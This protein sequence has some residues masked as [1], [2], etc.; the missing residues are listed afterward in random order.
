M[1]A[2]CLLLADDLE[3]SLKKHEDH[4][5]I[6]VELHQMLQLYVIADDWLVDI[7]CHLEKKGYSYVT[8][9]S[10][11]LADLITSKSDY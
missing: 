6:C 4:Q 7:F 11:Q 8:C 2:F 1:S 9:S 5:R 10:L 3:M